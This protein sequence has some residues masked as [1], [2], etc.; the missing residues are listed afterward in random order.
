[1]TEGIS[2]ERCGAFV[3]EEELV[4]VVVVYRKTSPDRR[5]EM[6]ICEDCRNDLRSFFRNRPTW[7][8]LVSFLL[9]TLAFILA[10]QAF[11]VITIW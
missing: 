10:L 6:R 5:K 1:M 9:L 4:T 8:L 2:C 11:G 7:P 3:S